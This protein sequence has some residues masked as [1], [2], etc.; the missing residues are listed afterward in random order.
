MNLNSVLKTLFILIMILFNFGFIRFSH[1]CGPKDTIL[2]FEVMTPLAPWIRQWQRP[3]LSESWTRHWSASTSRV[4][5]ETTDV[6][7]TNGSQCTQSWYRPRPGRA[8]RGADRPGRAEGTRNT[9]AHWNRPTCWRTS[10]NRCFIRLTF[11]PQ[12]DG[13]L[14]GRSSLMLSC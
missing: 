9:C 1:R 10:P 5:D 12:R 14:Y 2:V 11:Q 4:S 7:S 6:C 3:P 13:W 8:G